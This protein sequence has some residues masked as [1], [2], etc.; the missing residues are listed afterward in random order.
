MKLSKLEVPEEI[1]EVIKPIKD[2]DAAIRNFGIQQ[3]VGMCKVLLQSG[4]VPGLHLYTLNREVASMEVLKQLG[5]WIEDPRYLFIYYFCVTLWVAPG[6]SCHMRARGKKVHK[7]HEMES[8][9]PSLL[10]FDEV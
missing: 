3:A 5:L 9:P 10:V 4:E 7:C 6:C 1:M 8:F 2:N